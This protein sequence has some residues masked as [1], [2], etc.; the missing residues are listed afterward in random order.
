MKTLALLTLAATMLAAPSTP[1]REPTTTSA[2]AGADPAVLID[3][4]DAYVYHESNGMDGLQRNDAG[5]DDTCGASGSGADTPLKQN[6]PQPL[7]PPCAK[8]AVAAVRAPNP[9][10]WRSRPEKHSK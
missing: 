8:S 1:L 5:G 9:P 4:T 2:D 3:G 10:R 6:L 7:F